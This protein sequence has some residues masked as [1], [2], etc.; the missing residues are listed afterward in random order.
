MTASSQSNASSSVPTQQ[1]DDTDTETST[2]SNT[3][4]NTDS[5]QSASREDRSTATEIETKDFY[6]ATRLFGDAQPIEK[7][8]PTTS[9]QITS[10][11]NRF[12]I[13]DHVCDQVLKD[14]IEN[15]IH[16]NVAHQWIA[17]ARASTNTM[18]LK[19]SWTLKAEM[20]RWIRDFVHVAE[21]LALESKPQHVLAFV[22]PTGAGKS[23]TLSKIAGG[24]SIEHRIKV[25]VIQTSLANATHDPLLS[26]YA[27]VLGWQFEQASNPQE[28]KSCVS[29]LSDCQ[30]VLVDTPGC[31]PTDS[32]SLEKIQA[33]LEAI[34]PTA[35][36]LVVASTTNEMS[37]QRF[38]TGFETLGP[39]ALV[40][41]KLD[42]AGGLGP[43]FTSL[44]NSTLPIS[45][46]TF[47]QQIPSDFAQATPH[48]LAQLILS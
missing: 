22:G 47:G 30:V 21:P 46:L 19:D 8:N 9:P 14:L 28:A 11:N 2:A 1:Q 32:E 44:Q 15:G 4:R 17:A 41:T 45:Y 5:N 39:S 43:L 35:T 33:M 42:E 16:A 23:T 3:L 36:H 20:Q 38:E 27:K 18:L 12:A 34:Q 26:R 24:L 7:E 13:E 25:G 6:P 29:V 31:S 37:F 10:V 48:R 40:L